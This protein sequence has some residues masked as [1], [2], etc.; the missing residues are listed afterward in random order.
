MLGAAAAA[1]GLAVARGTG[2]VVVGPGVAA[3]VRGASYLGLVLAAGSLE[4]ML[5]VWPSGLRVKR[6]ATMVWSG[7]L[8]AVIATV[9]QLSLRDGTGTDMPGGDRIVAALGLRLGVL[10]AGVVWVSAVL[11]GRTAPRL[12]G[13][14]VSVALAC[15]WV[16]AGPAAPGWFTVVVTVAHISAAC[17]W[18]GGLAVLAV[19]L[20]PRG[21]TA[22]LAGALTRFSHVATVCVAV[23]AV[24]GAVHGWSRAGSVTALFTTSY[25]HSFWL[26]VAAVAAMLVVA[27][28]N[29]L[30]VAGHVLAR[31][32]DG[33]PPD[34]GEVAGTTD[35]A[36]GAATGPSPVTPPPLQ[37]LGLFLGAE[38]AFG[39]VVMVMT[40]I[41]VGAPVGR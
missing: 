5:L 17:V 40:G 20:L 21:P 18:A 29:R 4:F 10:L 27:N 12:V 15:T 36:G 16:Y 33:A 26:K 19:V 22:S 23:L 32:P 25:G 34:A 31:L 39:L 2:G 1:V 35:S 6:L 37:M 28:G 13:L 38:V 14:V 8:T 24:S 3:G 41:L 9:L 30:Y 11:T 7:W